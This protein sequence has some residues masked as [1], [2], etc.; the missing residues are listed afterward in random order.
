VYIRDHSTTS[1]FFPLVTRKVTVDIG[2]INTVHHDFHLTTSSAATTTITWPSAAT[3]TTSTVVLIVSRCGTNG[4]FV[5]FLGLG[6]RKAA[7]DSPGERH[8]S[9]IKVVQISV[10]DDSHSCL[11]LNIIAAHTAKQELYLLLNIHWLPCVL[12]LFK[13]FVYSGQVPLERKRSL[14]L[15]KQCLKL[16][17]CGRCT[18]HVV[19]LTNIV[20][21]Q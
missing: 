3:T 4:A 7:G 19:G 18:P 17:V 20:F 11:H 14:A 10:S 1:Q 2:H 15:L 16:R 5:T 6:Q 12:Q 13:R 8:T 9:G 21:T